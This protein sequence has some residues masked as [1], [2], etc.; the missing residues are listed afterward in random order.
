M[1]LIFDLFRAYSKPMVYAVKNPTY[2]RE[3]CQYAW[4]VVF[5][6]DESFK[7][8]ISMPKEVND[9]ILKNDDSFYAA[10]G[11]FS[12]AEGFIGLRGRYNGKSAA[13]YGVSN[14]KVQICNDFLKGLRQRGFSGSVYKMR[15]VS[16]LIQWELSVSSKDVIPL[17]DRLLLKHEEK[18]AARNLVRSL[19]GTPWDRAGPTYKDFRRAIKL[20]RNACV[21]AAKR[22]YENRNRM[23]QI[24]VQLEQEITRRAHSLYAAGLRPQYIATLLGRS[25]RTIYR[26]VARENDRIKA[27][28]Q[29]PKQ[30]D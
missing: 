3:R 20:R 26:R 12:D 5:D 8:L 1:R 13:A 2:F 25:E 4:R 7:F 28:G 19:A 9:G 15:E 22:E 10:L 27:P 14:S 11:G 6:L 29:T 24:R 18:I 17:V 23:R 21:L 30:A 16:G